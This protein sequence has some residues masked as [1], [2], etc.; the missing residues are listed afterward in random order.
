MK[1]Q[2]VPMLDAA[3]EVNA[4]ANWMRAEM[5]AGIRKRGIVVAISGGI[6]S[7]VCA[8]LAVEAVGNERVLGLLLPER[9]SSPKSTERGKALAE[10]FGIRYELVD[11]SHILEAIGCYSW[12][13][14]A[15]RAVFPEFETGWKMMIAL[16]PAAEGA[17]SRF[18]LI[19][20]DP[21]GERMAK[22]MP[23]QPYLQ[24]VAATNYKQRIR[25]TIEYGYADRY[26]YAVVGTPNKLEY[27]LGFYV[28]NGD[29]AADLKPI[30]HLYKSQV[31]ELGEY[32]G[33]ARDIMSATPSTDTYS[34]DQ[35][36]ED[37]YFG[38][39]LGTMDFVLYQYHAG[40]PASGLAKQ[41]NAS[42]AEAERMY[43]QIEGKLRVAEVLSRNAAKYK[44]S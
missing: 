23:L 9:D 20:E 27:D 17:F 31:Y 6:D 2:R 13:R 41:L 4:V 42:D 44:A 21:R 28:R 22:L 10:Q 43:G 32:F 1:A 36:Q 16:S 8:A 5:T 11:I 12:Q 18:R 3:S 29:G 7:A 30:A 25:K 19:V 33:I 14:E 34:L 38:L 24:L 26:N 39:P 15:A 35:D 40:M 37:F